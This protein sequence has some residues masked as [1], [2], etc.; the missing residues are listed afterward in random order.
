MQPLFLNQAH[1]KKK[2]KYKK[3][4]ILIYTETL[5]I[6]LSHGTKTVKS[7]HKWQIWQNIQLLILTYK[8]II[9]FICEVTLFFILS[10]MRGVIQDYET[11]FFNSRLEQKIQSS[12]WTVE[13]CRGTMQLRKVSAAHNINYNIILVKEYDKKIGP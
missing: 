6:L 4:A 10:R 11:V 9:R 13:A 8:I 1:G 3:S 2:K 12:A 7:R 5:K